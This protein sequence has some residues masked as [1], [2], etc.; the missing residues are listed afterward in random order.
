MR[1]SWKLSLNL[2]ALLRVLSFTSSGSPLVCAALGV[3]ASNQRLPAPLAPC[4][5][6]DDSFS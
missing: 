5:S 1:W 4:H 6:V 2:S 3:S